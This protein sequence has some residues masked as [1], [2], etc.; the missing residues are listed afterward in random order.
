[1]QAH[2][3][4]HVSH[5]RNLDG[6][7]EHTAD[8]ELLCDEQSGDDVKLLGVY[9]SDLR[10]REGRERARLL[11]G[12]IDEPDCF[13]ITPYEVDED[14]W[15]E[16]FVRI[17]HLGAAD[18][19]L[20][21]DADADAAYVS[22]SPVPAGGVRTNVV[23]ERPGRGDIVLDFDEDGFLVGIEIIGAQHVLRSLSDGTDRS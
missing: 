9:S 21:H 8:G 12:F 13:S 23:V 2:L 19:L 6:T 15:D 20:D 11:P 7:V 5:A 16:G 18:V 17:P 3:L 1:M 14:H 22:L 10:A 4:Y